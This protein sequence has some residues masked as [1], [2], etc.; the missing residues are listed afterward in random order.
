MARVTVEDCI[1]KVNSRFDLILLAAHRT[2]QLAQGEIPMLDQNNDK[3][4]VLA[5]REIAESVVSPED[6]HESLIHALQKHV[7]VDEPELHSSQ[8]LNTMQEDELLESPSF[9]QLSEE[10]LLS[11]IEQLIAPTKNED[12]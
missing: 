8:D 3:N 12:F 9:S 4:T 6:L 11:G 7:E 10:E 5:L 2:R 1:D